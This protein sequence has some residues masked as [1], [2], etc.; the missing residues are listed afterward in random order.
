M[1]LVYKINICS[2]QSRPTLA[3]VYSMLNT[4][5]CVVPVAKDTRIG[6][7]QYMLHGKYYPT[8]PQAQAQA[9]AQDTAGTDADTADTAMAYLVSPT[10]TKSGLVS[11]IEN[12]LSYKA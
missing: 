7:F 6:T 3:Q 2:H 4:F 1:H 11:F 9:Q 8:N 10:T 12:P 5:V